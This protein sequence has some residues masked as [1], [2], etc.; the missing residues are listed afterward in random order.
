MN[1]KINQSI[2]LAEPGDGFS[3]AFAGASIQEFS[4]NVTPKSVPLSYD[5]CCQLVYRHGE[6][7]PVV[8]L[9]AGNPQAIQRF[10]SVL[11]L[12]I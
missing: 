7:V 10:Y 3:I 6:L 11:F 9:S 1:T 5:Y 8:D 2:W 4:M 12:P